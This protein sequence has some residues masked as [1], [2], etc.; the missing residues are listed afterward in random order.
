M[1]EAK[2]RLTERSGGHCRLSEIDPDYK[3]LELGLHIECDSKQGIQLC[4]ESEYLLVIVVTHLSSC[5]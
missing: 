2:Q 1:L 3:N 5:C 4:E